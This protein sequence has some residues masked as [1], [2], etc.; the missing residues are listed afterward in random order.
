[1][2]FINLLRHISLKHMRFQKAR[3]FMA[4]CGICLGVAAMVSIDIVNRSVLKSFEDSINQVTGRAALQV[5]GADSGFPEQMLD[6]VQGVPGVEYALPVIETNAN[7]AGGKERSFMILG[8]DLLQDHQIRSYS[9]TDESADIPDPLLFLAK[10]DSILLTREMAVREGIKIDQEI[11][12]QTVQGIKKF[13]V[14]GLLDP[15]GPAK[16][17]GGDIAIM[18]IYAAQMVFG[19]EGRIDR[20]DVSFLPGET[21]NTMKDRIQRALPEGYYVDTPAGRTRQVELLLTRFRKII[22]LIGFMAIFVGMYLIYNAVSISVVQR[23]K[24]IGILR[25]LGAKRVQIITLFIGEALAVSALASFLGIGLG[26][27]FA[28]LTV[29]VVAQNVTDMYLKTSVRELTFSWDFLIKDVGIGIMASLAAAAFP[30]FAGA[31]IT[32]VSAIRAVPYSEDGFLLSRKTRIASA[33]FILLSV[34]I[35]TAYKTAGPSSV[36]RSSAATFSSMIFLVLGVSLSTPA[37]LRLFMAGFHRFFSP[38]MGAEVRLA[39]LNLQKNISRNAVAVSAVFYSIAMFVSSSSMIYSLN[40]SFLDYIEAVDRCDILVSSGHPLAMGGVP[41]IPMPEELWK[42]IE[43]VPGVLSADPFRKTFL[44]YD[45]RRLFLGAI[46]IVRSMEYNQYMLAAGSLKDIRRL[47]PHQ[48]NVMVNEGFAARYRIKPGDSLVLP[49]PNGPVSFRVA[50]IVVSYVSDSGSIWMDIFTY[51]RHW[52]DYLADNFSV[53]VKPNASIPTVREA[54]LDRFGKERKI[55]A[56]PSR[57]FKGVVRDMLGRSFTLI[58]AVNILTLIIAGLGIIITLL[59][60]VLERTREIG[61]LRS[62]GMKRNQVS[63]VVLIESALLGAAGGLL[64]SVVGIL[65]GWITL[66][67]FFRLDLG[68]S[69]QYH[70]HYPSIGW[71]LLLSI[72]FSALAGL[73]PA[74]R[75]AKT[76]IV[77]ALAYE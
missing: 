2:N 18:D 32:P 10:K 35:F 67:G 66:E 40:R 63:G 30:A 38:Y 29:G 27:V 28:K 69:V 6:K 65:T 58:N 12:V 51:Q 33:F 61:I 25:A 5:T 72:G 47:L 11:Q 52:R 73:Y 34:L 9:L 39:G 49:T 24:E 4:V 44:N 64:G 26:I 60:S 46:D 62:I 48:D 50:A 37:F 54:I 53:R 76:N 75:A 55:F 8:V 70:I 74:R 7:L 68:A 45:G 19:K 20:I 42:D 17:A 31:R 14:R 43:K 1:M 56:L 16:A 21:L 22:G 41:S 77:E 57:E 13:V 23:R 36:F 71:S 59:A 3:M 15:E